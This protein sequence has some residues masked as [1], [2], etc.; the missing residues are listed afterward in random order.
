MTAQPIP[1]DQLTDL[2]HA[3]AAV[4]G[5]T[6]LTAVLFK[7]VETGMNLTGATYGALGVLG[8]HGVLVEFLH[9]GMEGDTVSKIGAPP[10]GRGLLG[11]ITRHKKPVR[12]DEIRS[13]ADSVGFPPD[14][15]EMH[16]FLGVPVSVGGRVF[17]NIYLTEK[18][19]GFTQDDEAVVES[20]A[21]I[22]GAAISTARL[23]RRLRRLAIIEDRERIAR[24]LHDAIIQDLF[25]VGLTI[26]AQIRLVNDPEVAAALESTVQRLDDAISELR[27]FIFDLRP[28]VWAG[29]NLAREVTEV[30]ETI[31]EAHEADVVTSFKGPIESIPPSMVEDALQAVKESLSNALRHAGPQRIEVGVRVDPD[32]LVV[33]VTDDGSGFEPG[34]VTY[35]MGIEN[36]RTR[37]ANAGGEATITSRPGKGTTVRVV[38]PI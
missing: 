34:S 16:S 36:L 27:R 8:D 1:A 22:A 10:M 6:D 29:R 12:I 13:H 5:Q 2:V 24:D 20:L 17:G 38:F 18:D 23:Q 26:Q 33:I 32:S 30:V 9:A 11:T 37:A 19:G 14:H 21:V 28:P 25:A 7:T 4:A 15:P 35:G 31:A 3:A